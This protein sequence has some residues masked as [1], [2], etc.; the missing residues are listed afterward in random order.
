MIFFLPAYWLIHSVHCKGGFQPWWKWSE[1]SR[2][3]TFL[4]QREEDWW[5]LLGSNCLSPNTWKPG[6]CQV[7]LRNVRSYFSLLFTPLFSPS[8]LSFHRFPS[9]WCLSLLDN[10]SASRV[11]SAVWSSPLH[12]R[13]HALFLFISLLILSFTPCFSDLL[14][15]F[16][17]SQSTPLSLS[18]SLSPL[19]LSPSLSEFRGG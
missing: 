7:F 12:L 19:L 11:S 6:K 4:L 16:D 9:P 8:S 14:L 5:P 10:V 17:K 3:V 1:P 2:Q 18:L 13:L 15:L